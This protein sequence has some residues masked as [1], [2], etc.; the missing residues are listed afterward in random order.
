MVLDT[1]AWDR[2]SSAA[3]LANEPVSATLAKIAQPSRS[4]SLFMM[5][6]AKKVASM[7]AAGYVTNKNARGRPGRK[8]PGHGDHAKNG[9][10]AIPRCGFSGEGRIPN[11]PIPTD[12]VNETPQA[13]FG[14]DGSGAGRNGLRSARIHLAAFP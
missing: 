14:H 9:K 12:D 8:Q 10:D 7:I 3:A 2:D 11:M 1:V 5:I 6:L 13:A 4:G